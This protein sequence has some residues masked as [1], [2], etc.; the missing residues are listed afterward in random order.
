MLIGSIT[1]LADDTKEKTNNVRNF[2][3]TAYCLRGRTASGIPVRNGVV[4]V[5]PRVIPLGTLIYID[6][7]GRFLAADTGG[8]I[9]GNRLDIWYG[10]CAQAR[11]FGRRNVQVGILNKNLKKK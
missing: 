4:A 6:G 1:T 9:K 3:A 2:N 10:S 5:D 7:Y 8:A 11:K